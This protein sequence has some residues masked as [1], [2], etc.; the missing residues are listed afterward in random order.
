M[1]T[2]QVLVKLGESDDAA[3]IIVREDIKA[4]TGADISDP[5]VLRAALR[6]K[7]GRIKTEQAGAAHID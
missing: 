2:K 3:L 7:A 5:E 6:E 1:S 4:R